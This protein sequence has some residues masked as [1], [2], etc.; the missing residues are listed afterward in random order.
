[1]KCPNCNEIINIE[2]TDKCKCGYVFSRF[3]ESNK[4]VNSSVIENVS[5]NDIR[6]PFYSM[7][8]F[9]IKLVIASIPALIILFTIGITFMALITSFSLVILNN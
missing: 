2:G 1:M 4:V 3:Q 5:I 7:V 6:I 9:M 8:V